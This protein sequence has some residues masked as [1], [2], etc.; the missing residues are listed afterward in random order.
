MGTTLPKRLVGVGVDFT[1]SISHS[2]DF[3]IFALIA[4]PPCAGAAMLIPEKVCTA[5]AVCCTVVAAPPRNRATECGQWTLCIHYHATRLIGPSTQSFTRAAGIR[6]SEIGGLIS[7]SRRTDAA[8][9]SVY[10]PLVSRFSPRSNLRRIYI[11][12]SIKLGLILKRPRRDAVAQTFLAESPLIVT[13]FCH[14]GRE[15]S[16]RTKALAASQDGSTEVL[17]CIEARAALVTKAK[18]RSHPAQSRDTC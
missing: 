12:G 7:Q 17:E 16:N 15:S 1:V 9:R 4:V 13:V 8:G 3:D 5:L 2:G 10:A 6:L 18:V 11:C 14:T